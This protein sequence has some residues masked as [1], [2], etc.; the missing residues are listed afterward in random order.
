[1]IPFL[2]Y[3]QLKLGGGTLIVLSSAK[4]VKELIDKSGW[5]ASSR[6]PNFLISLICDNQHIVFT[7]D[8]P[9]LRI[10]KRVLSRSLSPQSSAKYIPI[11][12]AESTQLLVDFMD[13]PQVLTIYN[14][15]AFVFTL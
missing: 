12:E 10:L 6:P 4:A 5:N 2:R 3:E 8:S 7:P 11:L 9:H 15:D 13:Y 14:F 1:M